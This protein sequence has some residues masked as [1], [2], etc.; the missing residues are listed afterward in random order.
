MP[1][2]AIRMFFLLA[3]SVVSLAYSSI[4]TVPLTN[5]SNYPLVLGSAAGASY[6]SLAQCAGSCSSCPAVCT[7]AGYNNE[8]FIPPC[9]CYLAPPTTLNEVLVFSTQWV[10]LAQN[11][12]IILT[13]TA[14][15]PAPDYPEYGYANFKITKT[16]NGVVGTI[17]SDGSS[18]PPGF[19]L[20]G[21]T[22]YDTDI[23][24]SDSGEF[25]INFT[26]P[27]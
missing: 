18:S 15:G 14:V 12:S 2:T 19:S 6:N 21:V 27:D 25:Q 16:S 13:Y 8:N 1:F 24:L 26:I 23:N 10:N 20:N 4:S 9:L 5:Y 7:F 17:M 22:T 11:G 3:I